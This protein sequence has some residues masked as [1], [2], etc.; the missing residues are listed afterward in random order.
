VVL[1]SGTK[2]ADAAGCVL[3]KP[4]ANEKDA[5][6]PPDWPRWKQAI[7]EEVAAHKKLGTWSK[8]KVNDKK[9]KAVK[10]RF[11]FGIK[12]DAEDKVTRYK[13]R[14][15][16][17]GFN[18]VPGRDFNSRRMPPTVAP[19]SWSPTPCGLPCAMP[20][21]RAWKTAKAASTCCAQS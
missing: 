5:R 11:V 9:Y 1:A 16:A 17:Q 2:S 20:T 12:H 13:A 21:S 14:L 7:K 19:L 10:T 8:I 4:P 15:V 3:H 18:R 6:A